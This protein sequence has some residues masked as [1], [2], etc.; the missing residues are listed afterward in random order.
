M[1]KNDV[2]YIILKK[3]FAGKKDA[4]NEKNAIFYDETNILM[5]VFEI[6]S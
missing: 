2:N 5:H 3:I 6:H 4:E 1:E